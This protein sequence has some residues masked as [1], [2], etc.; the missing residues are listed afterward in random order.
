[1][2]P[3]DGKYQ[4]SFL[5]AIVLPAIPL[6]I[7]EIFANQESAKTDLE[8]EGQVLEVGERDLRHSTRNIRIYNGDFF[9]NFS[10]SATYVYA[11]K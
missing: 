9:Q 2:A 10:Y 5:M 1:M 7:C 8:S 4:T 11:K 6:I 3:F